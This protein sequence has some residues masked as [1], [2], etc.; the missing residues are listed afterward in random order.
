MR[1]LDIELV[2]VGST[3]TAITGAFE[4]TAEGSLIHSRLSIKGHGKCETALERRRVLTK[5]RRL[6]TTTAHDGSS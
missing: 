1:A 5:L 6:M 4:V 2:E 3:R